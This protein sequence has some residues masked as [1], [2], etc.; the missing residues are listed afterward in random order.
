MGT[1]GLGLPAAVGPH[2]DPHVGHLWAT[3]G[4]QMGLPAAVFCS[5]Q[6]LFPRF[7][8]PPS[9]QQPQPMDEPCSYCGLSHGDGNEPPLAEFHRLRKWQRVLKKMIRITAALLMWRTVLV[10]LAWRRCC[11]RGVPLT[12]HMEEVVKRRHV[13][14]HNAWLKLAGRQLFETAHAELRSQLE[15]IHYTQCREC[16][17]RTSRVC[18]TCGQHVCR[19]CYYYH[20]IFCW[21][22]VTRRQQ[23]VSRNEDLHGE[24]PIGYFA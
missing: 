11:L 5:I 8:P 6:F 23:A 4:P 17:Q 24:D 13:R 20:A 18:P 9:D 15:P 2:V 10:R 1:R 16:H 12:L 21:S 19:E 14:S 22:D 3:M 7:G